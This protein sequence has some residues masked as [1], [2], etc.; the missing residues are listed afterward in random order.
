[1]RITDSDFTPLSELTVPI[2]GLKK[3]ISLSISKG[4]QT[5]TCFASKFEGFYIKTVGGLKC[6]SIIIEA[7]LLVHFAAKINPSSKN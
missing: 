1:M 2:A 7:N 3:M 5:G 4:Y 6:Q